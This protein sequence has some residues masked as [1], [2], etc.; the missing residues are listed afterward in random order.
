MGDV[1]DTTNV[2]TNMAGLNAFLQYSGVKLTDE[3]K[4]KM[5]TIFAECDTQNKQGEKGADGILSGSEV[6][7]FIDKIAKSLPR[8]REKVVD[9]A[10]M[11]NI[12]E[13]TR[14]EAKETQK[15]L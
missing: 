9:F 4:G 3:E 2:K 14:S 12:V 13:D 6:D 15:E 10:V 5:N 7:N 11:M 1:F 8:L